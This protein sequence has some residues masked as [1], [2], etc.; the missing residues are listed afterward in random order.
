ML[1]E[2]VHLSNQVLNGS[3]L[4]FEPSLERR[5]P[6]ALLVTEGREQVIRSFAQGVNRHFVSVSKPKKNGVFQLPY[7]SPRFIN[8]GD[9]ISGI[10]WGSFWSAHS[11]ADTFFDNPMNVSQQVRDFFVQVLLDKIRLA[12][13][14]PFLRFVRHWI[15]KAIR[16]RCL[17]LLRSPLF[18]LI[19]QRVNFPG[20]NLRLILKVFHLPLK[21]KSFR[22]NTGRKFTKARL[23][24]LRLLANWYKFRAQRRNR[25][26]LGTA[27]KKV[28]LVNHV[29]KHGADLIRAAVEKPYRIGGN[30]D[31][32]HM[33][34]MDRDLW[35]F[36]RFFVH[37]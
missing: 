26:R 18:D 36:L 27:Y 24:G 11:P 3:R 5:N 17:R 15:V 4:S 8:R 2:V 25:E 19:S 35:P 33:T 22:L 23:L 16:R 7:G 9:S 21:S 14:L 10:I 30:T 31:T 34:Y 28:Q 20:R 37:G 32:F 1:K 13:A 6:S 29:R 12:L